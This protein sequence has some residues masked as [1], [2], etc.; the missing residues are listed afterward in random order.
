[1]RRLGKE[2]MWVNYVNGG[3]GAGGASSE[4]DFL[5]QWQRITDWYQTHFEKKEETK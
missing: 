1:M 5:D 2:V 3:H 4:A